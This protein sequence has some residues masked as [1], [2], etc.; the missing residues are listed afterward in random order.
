[1]KSTILC[2]NIVSEWV[3][4]IR[5]DISYPYVRC[6][7][8]SHSIRQSAHLDWFPP[9]HN[10]ALRPLHHE[11]REFVTKNAFNFVCLFDLDTESDG[12]DGGLDQD[13]LIFVA[14]Y[15][16]RVQ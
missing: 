3:F 16:Q 8:E 6:E 2:F 9:Q 5:K 4:V 1:M 10:E 15:R 13:T 12:I 14:R 11:T 7:L